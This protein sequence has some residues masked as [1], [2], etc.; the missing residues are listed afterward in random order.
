MGLTAHVAQTVALKPGTPMDFTATW[1][2]SGTTMRSGLRVSEKFLAV[3]TTLIPLGSIIE[4][5]Y[6][7]GSKEYRIAADT[8]SAIHGRIVDI[9]VPSEQTALQKGRQHITLRVLGTVS[10]EEMKRET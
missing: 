1:Y 4:M 9:Y 7:D 3:D 6:G 10:L 8:G 5:T 2:A